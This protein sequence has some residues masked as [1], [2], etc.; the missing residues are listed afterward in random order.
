MSDCCKGA[1]GVSSVFFKIKKEQQSKFLLFFEATLFYKGWG[2]CFGTCLF[3][4]VQLSTLDFLLLIDIIILVNLIIKS[5]K[6]FANMQ[7]SHS[8]IYC[9]LYP[10]LFFNNSED[11][12]IVNLIIKS[13]KFLANLECSHYCIHSIQYPFLFFK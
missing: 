10:L 12:L 8:C 6:F 1:E 3:L 7:W 4:F 11:G 2:G 5:T 9:I 13:T